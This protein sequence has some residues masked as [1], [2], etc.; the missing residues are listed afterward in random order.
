MAESS[1]MAQ[2]RGRPACWGAWLAVSLLFSPLVAARR[3]LSVAGPR[4]GMSEWHIKLHR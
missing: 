1:Y 2:L 4:E 3:C